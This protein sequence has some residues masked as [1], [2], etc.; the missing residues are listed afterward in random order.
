MTSILI[1]I[2]MITVSVLSSYVY[3]NIWFYQ[4]FV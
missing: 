4:I 1:I 3:F 2:A